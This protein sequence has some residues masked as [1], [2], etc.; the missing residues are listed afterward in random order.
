MP[1][2]PVYNTPQV[3]PNTVPQ[4]RMAAPDFAAPV[5]RAFDAPATFVDTAGQQAQQTGQGLQTLGRAVAGIEN[6]ANQLRVDDALNRAKEAQLNLTYGKDNGY[7]NLKGINA[8]SRPDGKP[9]AQEY[10]DKL[11]KAMD[12]ISADLGND[13]QRAMFARYSN[14]MLTMFRGGAMQHEA[15]EYKTYA[16][17]TSEGIQS[18]AMR[19]ISL[20]WNNPDAVNSAVDRIKAETLRQAQLM[21]KSAEWQQAQA[22]KLTSSAHKTALLSALE[23]NDPVY[24]NA[25]LSKY[26]GQ[27]DA[28]DIL[29]VRGYITKDVNARVGNNVATEYIQTNPALAGEGNRAFAIAIKTES[30]GRQ[31][32]ADGS[33]LTSSKGAIGIAQVMP[34]TAPEA[35]KLAGLPWDENRY[36][37]D[38][39]YNLA[40]GKAYFQKQLQDNGG[41][42]AKAYAAYNAGP[43]ALKDAIKNAKDGNWL[44]LLP[45]ETQDYVTG[46]MAA[47]NAGKG[48]AARPTFADI[49]AQL[50]ADPRLADPERY[51]VARTEAQ[52]QYNE[53]T[54]AIQQRDDDAYKNALDALIK[55]GGKF[56]DLP[57]NVRQAIPPEKYTSILGDAARIAQGQ[58]M[59]ND[60][61]TWAEITSMTPAQLAAMTPVEFHNKYRTHLDDAHLERGYS[62]VLAARGGMADPK[63]LEVLTTSERVKQAAQQVGILPYTGKPSEDQAKRFDQFQG[64]IDQRLRMFETTQLQGKRKASADELQKVID[65]T[66]MD[67]ASVGRWYWTDKTA[68]PVALM[69][70]DD[71]KNAYVTVGNEE[72]ALTSVPAEQRGIIVGKLQKRG[73]PVTEQAVA[74]LWVKAGKPK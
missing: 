33:P 49:D 70:A 5:A 29:A 16:L 43:G 46:N 3:A 58:H 11:Q 57:A 47:F 66:L 23:Q 19:D 60:S 71:L 73:L 68:Q 48:Q 63:H 44:A 38:E 50:R 36:R 74:E 51:K 15:Q 41:D 39:A 56:A 31:F 14:D 72:I 67:T 40:L 6:Q 10:G 8:L 53:Q 52:R 17:S 9:L 61:M 7:T 27:M 1:R 69:S 2:V 32:A 55:N 37:N 45:Q 30:G 24:A 62:M 42:L 34:P 54:V 26:S 59:V 20:N 65:N 21:G 18:T 25:Y 64:I 22:R 28:D 13:A 12:D 35:A 4:V